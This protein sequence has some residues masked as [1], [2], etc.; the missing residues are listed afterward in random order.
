MT[1]LVLNNWAL[2]VKRLKQGYRYHKLHKPIS[3]FP[4]RHFELID[5]YKLS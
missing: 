2:T 5:K 4:N 3:N 1:L